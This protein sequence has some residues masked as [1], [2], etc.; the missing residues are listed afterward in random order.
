MKQKAYG[1]LISSEMHAEPI[2]Q[3][4]SLP[5]RVVALRHFEAEMRTIPKIH[6]LLAILYRRTELHFRFAW[7]MTG[8]TQGEYDSEER[9]RSKGE[10]VFLKTNVRDL[11]TQEGAKVA[12]AKRR[13]ALCFI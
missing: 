5:W 9:K 8:T 4:V 13:D 6:A 2:D 7:F 11:M 10:K 1:R 3:L 12:C